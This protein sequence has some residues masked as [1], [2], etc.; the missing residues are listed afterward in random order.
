MSETF[1]Y[2]RYMRDGSTKKKTA[3]IR[4]RSKKELRRSEVK[5]E[6]KAKIE[7]KELETA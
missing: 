3:V 7:N 1:E 2:I 4:P 6:L 5:R